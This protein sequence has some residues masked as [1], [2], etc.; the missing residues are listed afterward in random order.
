MFA[1][2]KHITKFFEKVVILEGKTDAQAHI[3]F[4]WDAGLATTDDIAT[5]YF[6]GKVIKYPYNTEFPHSRYIYVYAGDEY[7]EIAYKV[8]KNCDTS[9]FIVEDACGQRV[10]CWEIE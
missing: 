1:K 10:L 3:G 2:Y 9:H 8:F 5:N 6:G 7:E 4:V